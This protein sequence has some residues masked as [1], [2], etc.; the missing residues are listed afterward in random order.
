MDE[1][2]L[3]PTWLLA[4][5]TA[6]QVTGVAV[7]RDGEVAAQLHQTEPRIH[8]ERLLPAIDRVLAEAGIGVEEIEA[9]A[10]SIGPGSFTGLRI[11]L[12]TVKGL[13]LG[14]RRPVAPVSTLAGLAAGAGAGPGPIAALL[15]ARRGEVYAAAYQPPS[16]LEPVV[17]ESVYRPEAL[18]E[19]LPRGCSVVAG[20]GAGPAAHALAAAGPELRLLPAGCSVA[21][22]DVVGRLGLELLARGGGMPADALLPRYLRRAE[23]EARR[24]GR[25]LE[26]GGPRRV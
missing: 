10:L 5:E 4:L 8:S 21:R 2:A 18:A 7:L 19:R 20:E 6:T 17:A 9:F 23:A 22:A 3:R 14:D 25:A 16:F 12:A 15:D 11:G 13:A 24:L 26:G 1:G